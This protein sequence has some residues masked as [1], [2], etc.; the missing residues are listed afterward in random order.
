MADCYPFFIAERDNNH[1]EFEYFFTTDATVD[2]T[3]RFTKATYLFNVYCGPCQKIFEI[4]FAP[5]STK[6]YY[7]DDFKIAN[8]IISIMHSFIGWQRCPVLYVCDSSDNRENCR[9]RLFEG[10]FRKSGFSNIY[11]HQC[12]EYIFTDFKALIG[13]ISYKDDPNFSNYF[14][15]FDNL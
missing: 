15:Q 6:E 7:F 8:T 1:N 9:A 12:I 3:I 4:S 11:S 13:I 2:Y 14:E 5:N 10:W